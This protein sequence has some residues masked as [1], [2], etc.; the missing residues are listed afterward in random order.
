TADD[1]R[2]HLEHLPDLALEMIHVGAGEA[3]GSRFFTARTSEQN[4]EAVRVVIN[5]LLSDNPDNKNL[6]RIRLEKFQSDDNAK[7]AGLQFDD[8]ASPSQ[9]KLLLRHELT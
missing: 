5:R 6:K 4:Y 3:G 1:L 2:G 8:E 7:G 9:V